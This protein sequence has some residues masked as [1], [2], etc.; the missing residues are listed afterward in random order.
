MISSA[1]IY[2][3]LLNIITTASLVLLL[4]MFKTLSS[5]DYT[6]HRLIKLYHLGLE[7]QV[8]FISINNTF[9][10]NETCFGTLCKYKFQA[11]DGNS[12]FHQE[13]SRLG[14]P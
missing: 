8:R 10:R 13:T 11:V 4:G 7:G 12:F 3:F 1:A 9:K 6:S 5:R 2:V 14:R